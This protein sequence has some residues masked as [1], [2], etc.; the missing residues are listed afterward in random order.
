MKVLCLTLA[1]FAVAALAARKTDID[2]LEVKCRRGEQKVMVDGKLR[3]TCEKPLRGVVLELAFLSDSGDVLITE[4][5]DVTDETLE[6]N[7]EQSFHAETLNP[8]GAIQYKIRAFDAND[9]ELRVGNAG[10]FVIE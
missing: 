9:R 7:D 10:P 3:V 4:K 2:V 1:I 6:K 5:T 8:P